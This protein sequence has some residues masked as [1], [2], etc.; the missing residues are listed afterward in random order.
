MYAISKE[1][2]IT[3]TAMMCK[4]ALQFGGIYIYQLFLIPFEENLVPY[5]KSELA[6][7]A[8]MKKPKK[9]DF[10]RV[11]DIVLFDKMGQVSAKHP[12]TLDIIPRKIRNS[13][14]FMGGILTVFT[15]DHT[16]IQLIKGRPLLTSCHVLSCFTMV[17]L[18]QFI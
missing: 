14:V 13:N 1:L 18:E 17:S 8:P 2:R 9:L 10:L 4:R 12:S 16:Q 11:V 15:I 7:L 5:Q 3:A 6:I